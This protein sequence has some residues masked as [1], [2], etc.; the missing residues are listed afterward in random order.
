M[1]P[2]GPNPT[3]LKLWVRRP[4]PG[5]PVPK[6]HSPL[7]PPVTGKG[8]VCGS[9]PRLHRAVFL[10]SAK[11]EQIKEEVGLPL[12]SD[13]DSNVSAGGFIGARPSSDVDSELRLGRVDDTV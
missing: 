10:V 11:E 6:T 2:V 8:K 4:P 7:H 1:V 9:L 5:V 12:R 3:W 13:H